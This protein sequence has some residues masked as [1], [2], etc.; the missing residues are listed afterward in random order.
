MKNRDYFARPHQTGRYQQDYGNTKLTREE[1]ADLG[2]TL[3]GL[4]AALCIAVAFAVVVT[5]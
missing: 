3:V 5:S 2:W 4:L 1:E